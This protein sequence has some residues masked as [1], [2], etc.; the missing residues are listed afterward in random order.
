M[1]SEVFRCCQMLSDVISDVFRRFQTFS[2]V[3]RCFQML[4]FNISSLWF[5]CFQMAQMFLGLQCDAQKNYDTTEK[6]ALAIVWALQHF[7]TYC[8]GHC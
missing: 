8:E 4:L 6:E 5:R 2:D 3:F 1:F 7:N